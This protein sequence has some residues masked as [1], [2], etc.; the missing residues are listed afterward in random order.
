MVE[1]DGKLKL[2][3]AFRPSVAHLG[4]ERSPVLVVDNFLADPQVLIDYAAQ[5][6]CFSAVADAFYPGIRAPIPQI[7]TFAV[8]A[9]LGRLISDAFGVGEVVK[10]L[11]TFSLVTTPPERLQLLQRL[12]H[13]DNTDERQLAVL[14]YLCPAGMGGT[15]FYRHRATGFE[16][17]RPARLAQYTNSM[18]AELTAH[19]P[20]AADYV[21]GDTD[22]FERI[23]G[24]EVEFN[25][26]LVYR[27]I[28]LHSADIPPD[29][30][31]ASDPRTGRLTANTFFY[32]R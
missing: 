32:C 28:S 1:L 25:R 17:I 31:F 7:Y 15:S 29:F 5:E 24:F 22:W 19:G 27:S 4:V 11:A 23:G 26:L 8:R 3:A 13:F 20:P 18:N 16:A 6:S 14:H 12:P 10:E 21:R 2:H 9:F 30:S